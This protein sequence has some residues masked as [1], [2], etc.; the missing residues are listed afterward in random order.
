MLGVL[1]QAKAH[2]WGGKPNF[3]RAGSLTNIISEGLL[4]NKPPQTPLKGPSVATPA[5]G[6]GYI[7]DPV[8]EMRK[9]MDTQET[10]ID[11]SVLT[12]ASGRLGGRQD[13]SAQAEQFEEGGGLLVELT[14][15]SLRP[16]QVYTAETRRQQ[17]V[18]GDEHETG[19]EFGDKLRKVPTVKSSTRPRDSQV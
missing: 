4:S 3:L 14:Q 12:G 7:S 9:L 18:T 16:R 17:Q 10:N 13:D 11:R 19:S 2:F 5:S 15:L 1:L 6:V 8:M